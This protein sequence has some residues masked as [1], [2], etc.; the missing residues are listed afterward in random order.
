VLLAFF[1]AEFCFAWYLEQHYWLIPAV[2]F[3]NVAITWLVT[4]RILL[5]AI[6]FPYSNSVIVDQV[7][8]QLNE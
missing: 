5:Q 3:F 1:A 4:N 2:L 8:K 6:V 7:T